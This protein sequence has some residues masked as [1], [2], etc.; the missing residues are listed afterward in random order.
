[1]MKRVDQRHGGGGQQ[2]MFCASRFNSILHVPKNTASELLLCRHRAWF[3]DFRVCTE[4]KKTRVALSSLNSDRVAP[5]PRPS[6]SH[7]LW[8][9]L[10]KD[11]KKKDFS[12]KEAEAKM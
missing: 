9:R 3:F 5:P 8:F 7:W 12:Q 2:A 1:M 10:C 6:P 4:K 11:R